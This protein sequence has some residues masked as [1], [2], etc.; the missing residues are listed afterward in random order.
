MRSNTL[1]RAVTPTARMLAVIDVIDVVALNP[2]DIGSVA[3]GV[4]SDDHILGRF[5]P[6]Q[7]ALAEIARRETDGEWSGS[8]PRWVCIANELVVG[9]LIRPVI[10]RIIRAFAPGVVLH[11]SRDPRWTLLG[12]RLFA[13]EGS[14]AG[15]VLNQQF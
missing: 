7:A 14:G 6:R 4:A 2:S 11:T 10:H 13:E 1:I 3:F 5:R 8:V 9:V 12:N 15:A